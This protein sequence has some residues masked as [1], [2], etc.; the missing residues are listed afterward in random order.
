MKDMQRQSEEG[1]AAWREK[2]VGVDEK[3]TAGFTLGYKD[4]YLAG[5]AAA[6][7]STG[8]ID[9]KDRLPEANQDVLTVTEDGWYRVMSRGSGAGKFPSLVTHWRDLPSLPP[10]SNP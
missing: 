2:L 3:M 7:E 1:A 8:W 5:H 6:L 10:T 9:C 4:G